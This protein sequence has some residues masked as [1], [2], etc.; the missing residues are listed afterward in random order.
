MKIPYSGIR[1]KMVFFGNFVII[2]NIWEVWEF[3]NIRGNG[4][5]HDLAISAHNLFLI[6]FNRSDPMSDYS[7]IFLTPS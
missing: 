7:P 4:N 2:P 6:S 1:L 5:F 3:D